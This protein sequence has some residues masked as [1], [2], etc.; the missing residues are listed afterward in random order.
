MVLLTF[1]GRRSGRWYTTPVQYATDGDSLVVVPG[2]PERKQWWRNLRGGAPVHVRLGG[3][4]LD[5]DTALVEGQ[6]AA[7]PL[8]VYLDRFPRARR[9]LAD[10]HLAVVIRPRTT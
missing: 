2:H 9:A 6:A 3:R 10:Q 1:R 4:E 5:A 7:A 8:A